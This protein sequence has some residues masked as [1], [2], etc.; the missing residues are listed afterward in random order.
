VTGSRLTTAACDT[1]FVP[2]TTYRLRN[3][4]CLM[5]NYIMLV[6]SG[7]MCVPLWRKRTMSYYYDYICCA[8]AE[9]WSWISPTAGYPPI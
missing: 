4:H 6:I 3:V 7:S 2:R 8:T 1:F 5:P 9:I